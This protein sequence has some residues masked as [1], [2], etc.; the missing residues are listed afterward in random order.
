MSDITGTIKVIGET[1]QVSEKFSKKDFVLTTGEQY[2]QHLPMQLVQAKTSLL[3]GYK[4]GDEIKVYYN[5]RG[6][7][8]TTKEGEVKYFGTTEA[9]KLEKIG[10]HTDTSVAEVHP[11]TEDDGKE[12]PF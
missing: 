4:V 3:D 12:L 2:P 11:T 7:E 10:E 9:W 6:R 8:Y 1:V 5:L